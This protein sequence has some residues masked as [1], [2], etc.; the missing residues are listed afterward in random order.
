MRRVFAALGAVH[1]V[2]VGVLEFV[3]LVEV[4]GD[5]LVV[6]P[7][8]DDLVPVPPLRCPLPARR[9]GLL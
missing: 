7:D 4:V 2:G 6:V 9:E 5:V 8:L 3:E 1:G